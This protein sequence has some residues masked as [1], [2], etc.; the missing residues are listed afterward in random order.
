MSEVER[1]RQSALAKVRAGAIEEALIAYD[2]ALSLAA[3]S[4]TRDTKYAAIIRGAQ[5]FLTTS[6]FAERQILVRGHA[7]P[8]IGGRRSRRQKLRHAVLPLIQ[9]DRI[10][11]QSGVAALTLVKNRSAPGSKAGN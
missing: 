10:C 2:T 7:Q 3:L 11:G 5:H 9:L 1:L 8:E 4:A 6:Q